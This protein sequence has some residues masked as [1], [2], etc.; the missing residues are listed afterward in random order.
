MTIEPEQFEQLSAAL[1]HARLCGTT[2]A[3]PEFSL[4]LE[5]AYNIQADVA[6]RLGSRCIGWKVGSTSKE[7]QAKLGTDEPGAGA[8]I[9][10]YCF[11][12]AD[13]V[14]ISR[15]HNAQVEVEFAFRLGRTLEPQS[16]AYTVETVRPAIATFMPAMELVGSRYS[17]GLHGAGRALVTADGGANIAFISGPEIPFDVQWDLAKHGC[18]L[19]INGQPVAHG[20]GA[21]ALG[22]PLHVLCWLANHLR[23]KNLP[24]TAGSIVTTGTCTG[25]VPVK[26][27]DQ[28]VADFGSLGQVATLLSD[29]G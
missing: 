6:S 10:R 12:S 29:A 2:V 3:A 11:R 16:L 7:A 22:H 13:T 4:S 1:A 24:L 21:R 18:A 15:H 5:E 14:A 27:G 9:E 25:L 19:A 8:L 28:L 23:E 17:S 26:P 20:H